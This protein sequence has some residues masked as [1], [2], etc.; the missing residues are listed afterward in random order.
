MVTLLQPSVVASGFSSRFE[1]PCHLQPGL[2]ALLTLGSG[3]GLSKILILFSCLPLHPLSWRSS[4]VASDL[5]ANVSSLAALAGGEGQ[6][7][8]AVGVKASPELLWPCGAKRR[9]ELCRVVA[10][11]QLARPS[12]TSGPGHTPPC[13]FLPAGGHR[14]SMHSVG[15]TL[16]PHPRL[17]WPPHGAVLPL[18]SQ[19][20]PSLQ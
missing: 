14:L 7:S 9:E 6:M 11:P 2:R 13:V 16:P 19:S 10:K 15:G 20:M 5:Q 3:E 17:C 4:S 18:S 1:D 12:L 8:G